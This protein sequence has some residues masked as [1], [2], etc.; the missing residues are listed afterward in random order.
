MKL[1]DSL[2]LSGSVGV[3]IIGVHQTFTLGLMNSYWLFM[4]CVVFLLLYKVR[5]GPASGADGELNE[6][7]ESQLGNSTTKK[8]GH[9]RSKTTKPQKKE[10]R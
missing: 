2:L 1:L 8:L 3:F 6:S 4:L 5:K 10:K 7:S 9:S